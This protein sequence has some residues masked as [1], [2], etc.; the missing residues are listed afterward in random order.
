M[1]Q[2]ICL[3]DIREELVSQTPALVRIRDKACNIN[4]L[5]WN[6]AFMV[7]A[8]GIHRLALHPE[9][10]ANAFYLDV[11]DALIGLD[12]GEYAVAYLSIDQGGCAKER[13]FLDASY[14]TCLR[15]W[16]FGHV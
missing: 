9:F 16:V 11:T 12:C 1:D 6:V 4:K 7:Y 14:Q 2:G 15:N 10:L 5:D 3:H 8:F 13:G